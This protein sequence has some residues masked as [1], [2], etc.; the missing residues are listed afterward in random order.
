[1]NNY[2]TPTGLSS[3]WLK[4]IATANNAG[5]IESCITINTI[6]TPVVINWLL[7]DMLSPQLTAFKKEVSDL[8]ASVTASTETELLRIHPA[9]IAEGGFFT[10]CESFFAHG[11]P[12][13][14]WHQL[15]KT[16]QKNVEQF[17][18]MDIT[19]FGIETINKLKEDVYFVVTM[20]NKIT[21]DLLGFIMTSVTP[22][23]QYGNIKLIN[24][25]VAPE[26]PNQ[27]LEELLLNTIFAIV[28]QATQ[29]TTIVRSTNE[30]L[31]TVYYRYGF[32][33]NEN[34]QKDAHHIIAMDYYTALIYN[35]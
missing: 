6:E 24:L 26:Y 14:D 18:L 33:K 27:G 19:L 8:A 3:S 31:L 5:S 28:P 32:I 30:Q 11:L 1:M 4:I 21:N 9:A 20:K 34:Q 12:L 29:I 13:T 22:A 23:L 7:T 15:E 35:R 10:G 2:K 25:I 16:I 17:Y